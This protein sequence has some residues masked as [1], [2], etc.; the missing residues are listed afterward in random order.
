MKQ[1][2]LLT[3]LAA[4][5]ICAPLSAATI[6]AQASGSLEANAT[7]TG[8]TVPPP[9]TTT[10]LGISSGYQVYL[11]NAIYTAT[12]QSIQLGSGTATAGTFSI[13]NGNLTLSSSGTALGVGFTNGA[14]GFLNVSGGTITLNNTASAFVIGGATGSGTATSRNATGT[15]TITAGN[16]TLQGSGGLV[17]GQY[18]GNGTLNMS[19]G[20]LSNIYG[21]ADRAIVVGNGSSHGLISL[22]DTGSILTKTLNI[23]NGTGSGT[24][25]ISGGTLSATTIINVGSAGTGTLSVTA[26]NITAAAI[27]VTDTGSFTVNVA[28]NAKITATSLA[29]AASAEFTL[30]L[31]DLANLATNLNLGTL[32][33]ATGSTINLDFA[34]YSATSTFDAQNFFDTIFTSIADNGTLNIIT[35]GTNAPT[36]TY[37]NADGTFTT[38]PIPEPATIA[39]LLALAALTLTLRRR[40]SK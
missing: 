22:S 2:L 6:N 5:L 19:G 30:N 18:A 12:Y 20:I 4:A 35:T 39:T 10:T 32:S 21:S 28:D 16:V 23:G 33:Y 37:N 38:T 3:L 24:I 13:Q 17:V 1:N 15:A 31:L 11:N 7:W 40:H 9:G 27:N 14:T 36:I 8:D 26:G 25:E 34:G 29:L